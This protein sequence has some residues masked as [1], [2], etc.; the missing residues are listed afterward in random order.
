MKERSAASNQSEE[1]IR[2]Q[3]REQLK[4]VSDEALIDLDDYTMTL[5]TKRK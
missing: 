2:N 4:V 3:R 1:S 5:M